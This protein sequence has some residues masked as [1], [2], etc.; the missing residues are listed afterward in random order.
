MGFVGNNKDGQRKAMFSRLSGGSKFV[1]V[2]KIHLSSNDRLT[3]VKIKKTIPVKKD[4]NPIQVRELT[5]YTE[6]DHDL[7]KR[8]YIPIV[9]NQIRKIKK[10]NYDSEKSI[11]AFKN[12]A[13]ESAKKYYKDFGGSGYF[14]VAD[15]EKT[16]K[17][18]RDTFLDDY[19]TG[20]FDDLK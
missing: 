10:G 9:K 5:L 16:A 17:D 3:G 8:M 6:N 14:S 13:D 19:K 15:R 20:N 4:F 2:P 1:T 7:Y 18:L 12:L 11:K